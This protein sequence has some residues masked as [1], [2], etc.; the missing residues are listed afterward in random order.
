MGSSILT[1]TPYPGH[2]SLNDT[3]Q[4]FSETNAPPLSVQALAQ[5]MC[6]NVQRVFVGKRDAIGC[7]LIA[8]LCGRHA[9]IEDIPGTG[10]DHTCQSARKITWLPFQMYL[11]HSRP[12]SRRC[13]RG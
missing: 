10:K 13:R 2:V 7:A 3:P 9:L 11:I 5:R 4:G 6:D 1:N 12:R 8:L